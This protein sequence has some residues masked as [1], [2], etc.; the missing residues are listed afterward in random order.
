MKRHWVT[1]VCIS[2][3]DLGTEL[4]VPVIAE[5]QSSRSIRD[6]AAGVVSAARKMGA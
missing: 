3:A 1:L 4:G 2:A 5:L 6:H